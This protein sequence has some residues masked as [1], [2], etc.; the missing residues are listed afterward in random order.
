VF[1]WRLPTE[2]FE[3]LAFANATFTRFTN[4]HENPRE[5]QAF[6]HAEARW[7]ARPN[8]QLTGSAEGYHIDQVFDLS[9]TSAERLT[10]RLAVTGVVGSANLHWDLRPD[11]WLE[12]K[13]AA[14]RDRYRDHS[15]DHHQAIG[16]VTVGHKFLRG[17]LELALAGQALRRNYDRRPQYTA[18]GR[19]LP[20]ADLR[21]RQREG[22][23]RVTIGW[24]EAQRWSTTTAVI[25]A[26]NRDNGSGFFNYHQRAVR[27][28]LTWT[29]R[30]WKVRVVGRAGRYDYDVQTEGIGL[31]PPPRLKEEFLGQARLERDWTKTARLY[32]DFAWERSRSND[33]LACYRAKTSSAGVDWAF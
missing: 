18:A 19:P 5:W 28:E 9:A 27:Q 4:S 22:E 2:R 29:R 13:P 16:R 17:R 21:F 12:L 14:Q 31:A 7:F 26:N 24:D 15:D 30:P 25:T 23:A 10:A 11:T 3:A 33:P 1:W 32:L 20:G 6:V 8:L